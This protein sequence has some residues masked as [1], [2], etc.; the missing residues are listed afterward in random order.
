[1]L[2][3][4]GLFT[5]ALSVFAADPKLW[6]PAP[7]TSWQWQ[8]SGTLDL[9]VNA[10]VFDIDMFE[11][12]PAVVQ[13]LHSRGRK[14]IC[15]V[16]VGSFEPGRPDAAKFPADVKGKAMDGWPD[17]KWLDIRRLDVLG[18]IM[19]ARLDLCKSKGFD[20]VEPDNVD[21]YTNK[22]GFSLTAADQLKYNKFIA[23]AAHARGLSVG[24][25]NDTDQIATLV[26]SFDWALNEEC[27][28]YKECSAYK[29]FADAGKAVF[30]V[31]YKMK[32]DQFC[33][34]AN[35]LNFNSLQKNLNLDAFRV[36]CRE[37]AASVPSIGGITNAASYATGA[38]N[39]GEIIVIFGQQMGPALIKASSIDL[40][41]DIAGTKVWFDDTAAQLI[42]VSDSQVSAVVPAS[43]KGKSTTQVKVDRGGTV[44]AQMQVAVKDAVP[45]I[46]TL[47]A[48]GSGLAA[49]V[50]QDGTV[51][52]ASNPA[53]RGSIVAFYA[54]GLPNGVTA[55]KI[56]GK[57]ADV[58]YAGGV[59]WGV[60]GLIQ[61]NAVIPDG[62][63]GGLAQVIAESGSAS[64]QNGVTVAVAP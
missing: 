24:L 62:V 55:V 14:V 45:G 57:P 6:I 53:P 16:D 15:Y 9:S 41:T 22:T 35:S 63:A 59:V 17:E 26:A 39:P 34:Q 12:D 31:E 40:P 32:P 25:K 23:D 42:Y 1:M 47:D 29:P 19:E 36:A 28:T 43:V 2:K 4:I 44:S 33:P 46:F 21:G 13:Q 20:G 48:S 38:V 49:A 50:N 64:S 56:G 18:P 58:K 60:P 61:I 30:Q 5:F 54:T 11:T 7:Q 37:S 52:L 8:L 27:F 3:T 10:E 51:N